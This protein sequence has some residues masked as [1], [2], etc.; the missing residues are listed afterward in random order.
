MPI[1][2]VL[3][4]WKISLAEDATVILSWA[5]FLP[6]AIVY[7]VEEDDKKLLLREPSRRTI[8]VSFQISF[9]HALTALPRNFSY[10]VIIISISSKMKLGINQNKIPFIGKREK[11]NCR[12]LSLFVS[13]TPNYTKLHFHMDVKSRRR[14]KKTWWLLAP[15][16][17]DCEYLSNLLNDVIR[18]EC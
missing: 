7:Y 13:F 12:R 2:L 3:L 14:D 9:W 10:Y 15:L 16:T 6:T 18:L 4:W 1:I 11:N 17:N 5:N 8:I